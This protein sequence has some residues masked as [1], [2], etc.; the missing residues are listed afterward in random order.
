MHTTSLST[1]CI[2]D[3][4]R[5]QSIIASNHGKTAAYRWSD[6]LNNSQTLARTNPTTLSE[7]HGYKTLLSAALEMQQNCN[8]N[9]TSSELELSLP[10]LQVP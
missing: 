9:P 4:E 10:R 6:F 3:C 5:L 2:S 7:V 1:K 8:G